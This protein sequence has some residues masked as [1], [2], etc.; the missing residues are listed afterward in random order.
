MCCKQN[1]NLDGENPNKSP[2]VLFLLVRTPC[3]APVIQFFSVWSGGDLCGW[4]EA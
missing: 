2:N 3:F 1:L 4:A